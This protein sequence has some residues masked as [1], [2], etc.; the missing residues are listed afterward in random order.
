MERNFVYLKV[1]GKV[2]HRLK[3]GLGER[4]QRE[5]VPT[6]EVVSYVKQRK[7]HVSRLRGEKEAG[8]ALPPAPGPSATPWTLCLLP[9]CPGGIF[10]PR[11]EGSLPTVESWEAL[12]VPTFLEPV[13]MVPLGQARPRLILFDSCVL[14]GFPPG[15]VRPGGPSAFRMTAMSR[16]V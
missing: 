9:R 12:P 15:V 2:P 4:A 1:P 14:P 13:P 6:R 7:P 11:S 8:V 10:G 5:V 16:S 3:L